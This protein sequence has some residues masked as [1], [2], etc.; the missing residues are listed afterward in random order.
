M[1]R[2]F[3]LVVF[4]A[5][6]FTGKLV[7]EYIAKHGTGTR[8]AIAGRTQSKLEA[9]GLDVPILIGD[10]L[11]RAAMDRIAAR[12]RVVCTTAGPYAKFGHALVAACADAGTHY[13]DLT[14]EVQFMRRS[15]DANHARAIETGARIVHTCGFDSIPSDLGTYLLQQTM[16]RK[17]G[18]PATSVTALFGESSGGL[19]GGT[20]ASAMNIAE[21]AGRDRDVRRLLANPYAL[22]P[23]PTAPRPPAPDE[24]SIKWDS[25]MKLF[26]V[27]FL[28]AQVNTRVVRRAHALAGFPWGPEFRYREVMSTPGS[29]RGLAMAVGVTAGLAGIALAMANPTLRN[30]LAKRVPQPGEGPSEEKRTHGYWKLRLVGERAVDGSMQRLVYIAGDRSGDPGYGSTAKMLGESALCLANDALTSPGGVQTPSIAMGDALATR[31]RAAGLTF[32][33]EGGES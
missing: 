13:C 12:T 17:F 21:E 28:M 3:D 10:A 33:A 7:A 27:P 23:D 18:H 11:D 8:W 4:G 25:G 2:D 31:L 6:G 30:L 5:T 32:A 14:G 15:I 9:L 1:A 16:V 24:R 26:T 20:V 22:D 29:A 19:S